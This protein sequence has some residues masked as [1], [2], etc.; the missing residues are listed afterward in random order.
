MCIKLMTNKN[1]LYKKINKKN[2]KS[3]HELWNNSKCTNTHVIR[4]REREV[5]NKLLRNNGPQIS[6]FYEKHIPRDS[7][8]STYPKYKKDESNYSKA[9]YNKFVQN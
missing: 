1:L 9:H 7:R 3:I 8:N 5:R 4:V 6:K 2:E